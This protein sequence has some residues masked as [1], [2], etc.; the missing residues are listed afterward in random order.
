MF[1]SNFVSAW[2]E[3]QGR[4]KDMMKRTPRP[5]GQANRVGY[6]LLRIVL[7]VVFFFATKLRVEGVKNVPR[8]GPV[9]LAVN[10]IHSA[11]IPCFSLRIPR[12]THYMA[13]IELFSVPLL[14]GFMRLMGSFP[15]RRGEGDREAL[16][17]SE[18]LLR[19]GEV[20]VVF[21]EGHRSGTGVLGSGH[22]GAALIALHS[23]AP[24]VPCAIMGTQKIFK[25]LRYG[26]WAPVVTVRYGK[27][28]TLT[29]SGSR[30]TRED[31]T[32]GL[33]LIMYYIAV[34]LPPEYRGPYAQARLVTTQAPNGDEIPSV[35]YDAEEGTAA[36]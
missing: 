27:P 20:V 30:I 11:D 35:E 22:P 7:T 10:H 5:D 24:I 12:V 6:E 33:D 19:E 15:V 36:R 2:G 1:A 3:E 9:I 32:R 28:F 26:P 29:R 17:V 13:K 4:H 18:R 34:M 25:G 8:Q 23:G 31:L 14:G 21:P 16:K